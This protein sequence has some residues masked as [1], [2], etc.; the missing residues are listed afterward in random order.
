MVIIVG[1]CVKYTIFAS[2]K[3]ESTSIPYSIID[4]VIIKITNNTTIT[5]IYATVLIC[6][7]IA[8]L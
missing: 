2:A 5:S 1:Y 6:A 4:V 3:G 7:S 8:S